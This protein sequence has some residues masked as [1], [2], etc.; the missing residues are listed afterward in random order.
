MHTWTNL[1][2]N[3]HPTKCLGT[4]SSTLGQK[5][6]KKSSMKLVTYIGRTSYLLHWTSVQYFVHN[7]GVRITL[8][9]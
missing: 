7:I 2:L 6:E 1:T 3:T 9:A 4:Y 5:K 8:P